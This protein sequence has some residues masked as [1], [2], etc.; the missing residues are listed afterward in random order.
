MSSDEEYSPSDD[1]EYFDGLGN[2]SSGNEIIFSDGNEEDEPQ[3]PPS[4]AAEPSDW[5][6][7]QQNFN[8]DFTLPPF[9]SKFCAPQLPDPNKTSPVE[10]VSL[11]LTDS[12][13]EQVVTFTNQYA[14][15][16]R[17]RFTSQSQRRY[18]DA[19]WKDGTILLK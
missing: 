11:F 4:A 10:L 8:R 7:Y 3:A 16:Q 1:D 18:H 5:T 17:S 9:S 13:L 19:Y 12:L 14:A 15:F 2:G 6:W